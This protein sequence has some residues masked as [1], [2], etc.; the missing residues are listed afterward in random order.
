MFSLLRKK[1]FRDTT[2][3]AKNLE[4]GDHFEYDAVPVEVKAI[5]PSDDMVIVTI[6]RRQLGFEPRQWR[7]VSLYNDQLLSV[8]RYR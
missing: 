2:I 1:S 3:R 4:L 8:M 5:L 7:T 6:E